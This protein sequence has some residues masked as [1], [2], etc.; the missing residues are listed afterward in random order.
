MVVFLPNLSNPYPSQPEA[1]VP[2]I[3]FEER[4]CEILNKYCLNYDAQKEIESLM[5]D[6]SD[7]SFTDGIN[8]G[9]DAAGPGV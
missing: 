8:A 6:L 2:R 5:S 4:W 1:G 9:F 7:A 3:G